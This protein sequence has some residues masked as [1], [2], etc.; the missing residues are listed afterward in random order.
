MVDVAPG[1]LDRVRA[2]CMALPETYE[3][4]AWIG[5]RW[6]IRKRTFAHVVTI[7]EDG[8]ASFRQ[9][10]DVDGEATVVTFRAPYEEREALTTQ[11]KPFY[12]AGWGRDAMGMLLDDDTDWDEVTELLT[13]SYCMLAP[14][15]LAQRTRPA[16][17]DL[18]APTPPEAVRGAPHPD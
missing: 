10:F 13:D 1:I 2:I 11:G 5:V 6:R 8:P 16:Q 12:Y 17:A 15:K 18:A 9:A 7:E 3:E 14:K 4:P